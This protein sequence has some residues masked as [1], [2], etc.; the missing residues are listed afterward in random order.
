VDHM[1]TLGCKNALQP[2]GVKNTPHIRV[3]KSYLKVYY[4]T[5]KA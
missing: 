4:N 5:T 2:K 3:Y 1:H